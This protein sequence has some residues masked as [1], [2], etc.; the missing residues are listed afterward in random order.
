MEW[1]ESP[2][3][4]CYEVSEFGDVRRCRK[5]IRGGIIGKVMK[6]YVRKD[7]YRMFILR[8][9]EVSNRPRQSVDARNEG[10]V[11]PSCMNSIMVASSSRPSRLVPLTFSERMTSAPAAWGF[12]SGC[13]TRHC[14]CDPQGNREPG[15]GSCYSVA[16]SVSP[17]WSSGRALVVSPATREVWRVGRAAVR[18]RVRST[19]MASWVASSSCA[20]AR[21]PALCSTCAD[22]NPRKG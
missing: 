2:S 1:R 5:G 18:A 20:A 19:V 11:S 8:R 15:G 10:G 12:R 13:T 17:S 7:G 6:A 3:F 22:S 21:G 4:P 14:Q 16:S 9:D